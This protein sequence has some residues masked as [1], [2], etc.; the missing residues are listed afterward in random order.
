MIMEDRHI[1]ELTK[2]EALLV[3]TAL[4]TLKNRIGQRTRWLQRKR[5][6]TLRARLADLIIIGDEEEADGV[7]KA[8]KTTDDRITRRIEFGERIGDLMRSVKEKTGVIDEHLM[9]E[10]TE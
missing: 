2:D 3:V 6:P 8:I 9:D 5:M 4:G 10:E 1:I 7:R